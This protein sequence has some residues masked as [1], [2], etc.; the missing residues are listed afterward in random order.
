M[1][2]VSIHYSRSLLGS[3]PLRLLLRLARS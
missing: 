2:R 3:L 1:I